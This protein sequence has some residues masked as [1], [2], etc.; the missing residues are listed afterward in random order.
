MTAR[1]RGWLRAVDLWSVVAETSS[2]GCGAAG[3]ECEEGVVL[4]R[5]MDC[6]AVTVLQEEEASAE[7]SAVQRLQEQLAESQRVLSLQE[8]ERV[9]RRVRVSGVPHLCINCG[10]LHL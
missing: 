7:R 4:C 10:L 3:G 1:L 6:V 2:I 9:S 5:G 8:S